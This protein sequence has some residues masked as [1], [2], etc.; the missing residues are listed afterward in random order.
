MTV[1]DVRRVLVIVGH[2]VPD[3]LQAVVRS[4]ACS[5]TTPWVGP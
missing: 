4:W 1:A 5:L 3:P 2:P